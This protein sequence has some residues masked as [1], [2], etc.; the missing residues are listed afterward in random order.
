MNFYDF[1]EEPLEEPEIKF[2]KVKKSRLKR[3]LDGMQKLFR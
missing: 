1:L 2:V 3:L